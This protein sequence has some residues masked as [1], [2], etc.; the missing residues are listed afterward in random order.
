METAYAA[1]VFDGEGSV[2]IYRVSNGKSDKVYYAVRLAVVGTHRPMIAALREHFNVGLFTTQKRQAIQHTPNGSVFGKQGWLWAVQ[3]RAETQSV[4][5]Q[6]LPHLIEKKVQA[7]IALAFCRGEISGEVAEHSCKAAKKF[8]FPIEDFEEY[9]SRR[10][11]GQ[12]AG[13]K[14]PAATTSEETAV[15]IK[16]RLALGHRGVDIARELGVTKGVVSR[17][18]TG[19]AWSHL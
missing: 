5:E 13:S 16:R 6:I 3:S 10:N 12:L 8:S 11:T 7:E 2:G 4:L 9:A 19:K 1:G 18:N 15:E 17:I 14:N